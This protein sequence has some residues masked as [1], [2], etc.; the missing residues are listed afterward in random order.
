VNFELGDEQRAIDETA[1]ELLGTRLTSER[2]RALLDAGKD[3]TDLW[4][5]LCALGWPGIAV[6][7]AYGGQGLG[8]VELA[9]VCERLGEA[10]APVPLLSNAAAAL[11]L[12][13]AGSPDQRDRFLPGMATG[14]APG[15]VGLARGGTAELVAG[16]QQA[17]CVILGEEGRA[18][19]AEPDAVVEP[20]A[21][22]DGLRRYARVRS[23]AGEQLP[24]DPA[25]ALDRADVLVAAE[26]T[27]LAQRALDMAVAYAREREQFGRPIGTFQGVS[28]RCARML[29]ETEESRSLT[30][31]A[32]WAADA[33]PGSLP[34]AA[35]VAKVAAAERA[36]SVCASSLQVHGGIGFSWEHD[37]H[38]VLKRA[39]ASALLFR[40]ARELRTAI[41]ALRV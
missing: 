5:E 20:V 9:L 23:T 33:E 32:A 26:L 30:R 22:I 41:A 15:A 3:D 1:R 18:W 7:E 2:L 34:L 40:G 38:L 16:A 8:T 24:G 39:R 28:H 6:A 35:A 25:P 13:A 10:L 4:D 12:A 37:L 36:W 19:I 27:G 11:V 14:A 29:L 17:A 21:C 31:F